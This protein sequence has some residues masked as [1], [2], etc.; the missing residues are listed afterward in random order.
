MKYISWVLK[1]KILVLC[2]LG[3][4][5]TTNAQNTKYIE[6]HKSIAEQLAE[7][8]GIPCNVILGIAIVE[9]S[10][11]QSKNSKKLNNHFGIVGKNNLKK[12]G[13][14]RSR[15]KGYQTDEESFLDFCNMVSRKAFYPNLKDSADTKVWISALSK[16]GYSEKPE[17]WENRVLKTISANKL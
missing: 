4:I 10:A 9:S 14:Y 2:L 11:G 6:Q 12:T 13:S 8:F 17:V 1:R 7:K 15:Y 5:V 16:A 3:V